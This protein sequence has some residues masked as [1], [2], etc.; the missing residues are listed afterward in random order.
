MAAYIG[1]LRKESDS[2]FGVSF[3]DFPGCVTAGTSLDEARAFAAEALAFHIEGLL[4]DGDDLPAPSTLE[5]VMADSE[6]AGAVAVLVDSPAVKRPAARINI[7]IDPFV[8]KQ[9]DAYTE[10]VGMTRS[11]F[12]SLAAQAELK[13]VDSPNSD[14][15]S[16]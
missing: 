6:N 8:L 3:P 7:S 14:S 12:I 9:I 2:D 5:D 10:R 1:L 11:G 4:E 16:H 15:N 13:R